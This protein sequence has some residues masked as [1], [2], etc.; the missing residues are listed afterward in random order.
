MEASHQCW[1][2]YSLLKQVLRPYKKRRVILLTR[3]VVS[4]PHEAINVD[5]LLSKPSWSVR[6]LLPDSQTTSS[7]EVTPKQLHHLLRL[8]ALPQPS[9]SEEETKMLQTLSSQLHFVMEI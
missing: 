2:Y 5:K 3:H 1:R 4:K 6:S 8:S 9:S 7:P